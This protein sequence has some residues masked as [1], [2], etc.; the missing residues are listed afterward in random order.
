[1]FLGIVLRTIMSLA[2]L[3]RMTGWRWKLFPILP[4]RFFDYHTSKAARKW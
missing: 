4:A 3:E 2:I 1:M